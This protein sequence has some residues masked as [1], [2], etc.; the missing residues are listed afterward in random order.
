MWSRR[1]LIGELAVETGVSAKTLRFYED[2][3]LLRRPERTP[4]G[5]RD[6][7]RPVIDRV[8]FIKQA[9]AAGLT[10]RQI[11]EILE[12]RDGGRPPCLHVAALVDERLAEVEQRLSEL[13]RSRD[14]L[15]RLRRRL[16]ELDPADCAPGEICVAIT[17]S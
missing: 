2:R 7:P 15:R 9:Q 17:R 3:G 10:L 5:Y 12:V 14:Q 16:D 1:L 11:G 6:Y 4:G 13:R 8:G